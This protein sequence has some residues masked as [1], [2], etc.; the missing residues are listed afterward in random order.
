MTS[1][2]SLAMESMRHTGSVSFPEPLEIAEA[3]AEADRALGLRFFFGSMTEMLALICQQK[4]ET[5]MGEVRWERDRERE[6]RR[7]RREETSLEN[8][9]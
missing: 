9:A 8:M 2:A 4:R 1:A 5:G 7:K 3:D 6:R